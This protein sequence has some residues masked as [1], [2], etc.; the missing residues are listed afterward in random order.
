MGDG[1]SRVSSGR[2]DT[3]LLGIV[4]LPSEVWGSG[5]GGGAAPFLPKQ[6]ST[7]RQILYEAA[8]SHYATSLAVVSSRM[9]S[10]PSDADRSFAAAVAVAVATNMGHMARAL[11]DDTAARG[12]YE[13]AAAVFAGAASEIDDQAAEAACLGNILVLKILRGVPN[14]VERLRELASIHE[15]M[16]DTHGHA[17]ALVVMGTELA[18]RGD[19]L[20]AVRCLQ[21]GNVLAKASKNERAGTLARK[22]LERVT[23]H[24]LPGRSAAAAAAAPP[25][26]SSIAV[27]EVPPSS[28]VPTRFGRA[29]ALSI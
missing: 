17:T 8:H 15:R 21:A 13:R 25:A 6:V 26:T 3:P 24:A 10:S 4:A 16:G 2:A 28:T 11:G 14:T 7:S 12:C 29:E 9:T 19:E 18:A 27:P 23:K 5:G 22:I 1:G 20:N